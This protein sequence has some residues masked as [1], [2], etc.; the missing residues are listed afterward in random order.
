MC[1]ICKGPASFFWKMQQQLHT[2]LPPSI[3]S[4]PPVPW[5]LSSNLKQSPTFKC[6]RP[7]ISKLT[8]DFQEL[9]DLVWYCFGTAWNW[10]DPG[11]LDFSQ[12]TQTLPPCAQSVRVNR[13]R[14]AHCCW[15]GLAL[16]VILFDSALTTLLQ[17]LVC[18]VKKILPFVNIV[19]LIVPSVCC[20]D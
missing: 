11:M 7:I 16:D 12:I 10:Q 4:P 20:L 13:S 17:K 2:V 5:P 9:F 14:L 15:D 1:S 8:K 18:H 19:N 6:T 3:H